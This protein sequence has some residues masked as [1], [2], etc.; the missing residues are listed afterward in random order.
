MNNKGFAITTMLY[1]T[2]LV[3]LLLMLVMFNLLN[4][5][6]TNMDKLIEGN[7]GARE[8]VGIKCSDIVK[9]ADGNGEYSYDEQYGYK[10]DSNGN[11]SKDGAGNLIKSKDDYWFD[12]TQ[13]KNILKLCGYEE[14]T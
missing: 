14:D 6:K 1:G 10:R 7:G 8:I 11:L 12:K 4:N 5:F 3:F 13:F 2:F 9:D